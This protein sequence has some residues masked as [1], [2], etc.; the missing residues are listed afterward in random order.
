MAAL[1]YDA[2]QRRL[3]VSGVCS[4]DDAPRITEAVLTLA[5]P[6]E[7][8]IVDLTAVTG[9]T[10]AVA[11]ALLGAQGAIERCRVTLLRKCDGPV[12]RCLQD[13]GHRA[14]RPAARPAARRSSDG[15]VA[16]RHG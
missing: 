16:L 7:T 15:V 11:R 13:A 8:L 12:D 10:V 14:R 9:M 5:R 1:T 4:D 6:D 2:Q 3:R